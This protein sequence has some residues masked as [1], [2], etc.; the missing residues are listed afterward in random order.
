M[1]IREHGENAALNARS[2]P[3]DD[4]RTAKEEKIVEFTEFEKQLLKKV[5]L[6]YILNGNCVVP[7]P[8]APDPEQYKTACGILQ[9]LNPPA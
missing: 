2:N 5:L 3:P 4:G 6:N 7:V 9:K 1:H 8:L